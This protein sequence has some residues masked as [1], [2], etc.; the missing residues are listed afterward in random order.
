[1][2]LT[3][4]EERAAWEWKQQISGVLADPSSSSLPSSEDTMVYAAPRT[5]GDDD[6][7]DGGEVAALRMEAGSSSKTGARGCAEADLV[8]A[9]RV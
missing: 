6:S 1:M 9:W 8:R 4:D 7:E 2:G 3:F 5:G